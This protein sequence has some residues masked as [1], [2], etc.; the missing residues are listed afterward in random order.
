MI[1]YHGSYL[2][3]SCPDLMH[4]RE[5]VDFG[6]GFYTTPLEEQAQKWAFRFKGSRGRGVVSC[7]K[8]SE[9]VFDIAKVLSFESYDEE[10]LDFIM[11]CRRG[12]DTSDYDIVMG[13][14]ADDRVFNTLELYIDELIDSREAIGRLR[15]IKPNMQV[16]LRSQMVLDDY[17][18]FMGSEEV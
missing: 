9:S 7:Y 6:R 13:G 2:P 18:L 14:M 5:K 15:F 8:L 16:C 3:V 11:A 12:L 17:L 4:S 10:W 1:L